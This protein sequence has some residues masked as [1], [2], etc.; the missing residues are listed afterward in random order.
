M[1]GEAYACEYLA[2]VA[3]LVGYRARVHRAARIEALWACLDA[4]HPV[5]VCV[6]INNTRTFLPDMLGGQHTHFAVVRGRRGS[7]SETACAAHAPPPPPGGGLLRRGAV[8]RRAAA[9]FPAGAANQ[10][11]R[12]V[13]ERV[14][15]RRL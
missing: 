4:G 10:P 15:A 9:S 5:A 12:T 2:E 11:A 6:D 1:Y 14:A 8:R 3:R 13:A 7:G